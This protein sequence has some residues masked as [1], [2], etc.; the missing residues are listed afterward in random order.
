MTYGELWLLPSDAALERP[1]VALELRLWRIVRSW[2]GPQVSPYAEHGGNSFL[3]LD[4]SFCI[5]VRVVI[6]NAPSPARAY[7]TIQAAPAHRYDHVAF[8]PA[9]AFPASRRRWNTV[10]GNLHVP[11]LYNVWCCHADRHDMK[12]LSAAVMLRRQD[13]NRPRLD[14]VSVAGQLELVRVEFALENGTVSRTSYDGH[15]GLRAL[16]R[17]PEH[18]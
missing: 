14:H 10:Q 7:I 4:R 2:M 9:L 18:P 3:E 17:C 12:K 15:M 11:R 6:D 16:V 8:R 13:D 5:H 1:I